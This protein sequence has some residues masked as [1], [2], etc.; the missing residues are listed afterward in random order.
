MTTCSIFGREDKHKHIRGPNF[1]AWWMTCKSGFQPKMEF[2]LLYTQTIPQVLVLQ[3]EGA[4]DVSTLPY[5]STRFRGVPVRE[6]L[7]RS[8]TR[9]PPCRKDH[10]VFYGWRVPSMNKGFRISAFGCLHTYQHL[11]DT[12]KNLCQ[13]CFLHKKFL[14]L[15]TV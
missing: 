10:A 8:A 5:L 2:R 4:D 13:K 7:G 15:M 11:A 6:M 14:I 12:S 9:E 1:R 3:H